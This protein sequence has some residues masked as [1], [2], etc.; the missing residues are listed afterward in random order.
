ML[1]VEDVDADTKKQLNRENIALVKKEEF[2]K[3]EEDIKY[4]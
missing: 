4:F 3:E 1:L 2:P